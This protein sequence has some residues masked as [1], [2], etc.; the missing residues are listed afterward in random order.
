MLF[1]FNL[2]TYYFKINFLS[3]ISPGNKRLG[4]DRIILPVW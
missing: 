4:N 2:L 3:I 1:M